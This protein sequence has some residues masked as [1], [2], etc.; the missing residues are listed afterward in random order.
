MIDEAEAKAKHEYR[1]TNHNDTHAS[2]AES[3][4][5]VVCVSL[6]ELRLSTALRSS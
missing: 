5:S 6:R 2:T 4:D 3:P 1:E